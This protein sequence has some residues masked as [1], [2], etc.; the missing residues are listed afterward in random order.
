[1]HQRREREATKFLI[2]FLQRYKI[3]KLALDI[4][5]PLHTYCYG[6]RKYFFPGLR[7]PLGG[8]D[9]GKQWRRQFFVS[10][11]WTRLFARVLFKADQLRIRWLLILY[12]NWWEINIK[13]LNIK[14]RMDTFDNITNSPSYFSLHQN[15]QK[16]TNYFQ[17][18]VYQRWKM[19]ILFT[20]PVQVEPFV[21]FVRF[22]YPP[23]SKWPI[24]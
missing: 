15:E 17:T 23:I 20:R 13:R 19:Y 18:G 10:S 4:T 11:L 6:S 16:Y 14:V 1:M 3:E 7:I 22:P 21:F 9:W 24:K 8:L 12:L 2:F 5:N